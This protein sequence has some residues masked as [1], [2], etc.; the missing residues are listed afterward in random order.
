MQFVQ[1]ALVVA[2]CTSENVPGQHSRQSAG[3]GMLVPVWYVPAWQSWQ[4]PGTVMPRPV[5]NVPGWQDWHAES[6]LA[7]V[8]VWNVPAWHATQDTMLEAG[9]LVE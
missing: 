5:W 2:P 8:E 9:R 6:R 3:D 1:V 4:F 7:P